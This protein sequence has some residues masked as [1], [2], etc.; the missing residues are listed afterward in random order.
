M[1]YN[2]DMK[3]FLTLFLIGVG[4]CAASFGTA[5][6]AE[7]IMKEVPELQYGSCFVYQLRDKTTAQKISLPS[8]TEKAFDC[9]MMPP[10]LSPDQKS[11]LYYDAKKMYV[12]DI[13]TYNIKKL[14]TMQAGI[15]GLTCVWS[16]SS[17][18]A[19]CVIIN[20]KKYKTK[21][22]IAA[23]AFNNGK[24]KK[25]T[26]AKPVHY[27]CA[28]NVCFVDKAELWLEGDEWLH[29]KDVNSK[30]VQRMKTIKMP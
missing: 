6:A 14:L 19:A 28:N 15:K 26:L 3:K 10:L 8:K 5:S 4:L 21:T 25:K 20:P 17:A 27:T 11:I 1:R 23:L 16:K 29:Y 2:T 22:R 7:L 30:E 9:P 24:V 13:A 18:E 12:L